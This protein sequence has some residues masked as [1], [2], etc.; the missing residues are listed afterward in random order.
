MERIDGSP[1]AVGQTL[2]PPRYGKGRSR[3]LGCSLVPQVTPPSTELM[4]RPRQLCVLHL[5]S[6]KAPP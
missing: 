2:M 1:H 3:P 6:K 5:L 4:T